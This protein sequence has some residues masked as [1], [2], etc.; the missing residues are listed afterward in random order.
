M[1]QFL[2]FGFFVTFV[3]L[4]LGASFTTVIRALWSGR[5]DA[6]SARWRLRL[7]AA[8]L[9]AM[10]VA[11]EV[12]SRK[13]A[14]TGGGIA[15]IPVAIERGLTFMLWIA[16]TLIGVR[17][18]LVRIAD[19]IFARW[20]ARAMNESVIAP[21][22]APSESPA[23]VL[24]SPSR[25]EALFHG[26]GI[27]IAS[28]TVAVCGYAGLRVAGELRVRDAEV[29]IPDLPPEFE[30]LTLVQLTDIHVGIFTGAR[31]FARV[32]ERTN[33]LRGDLVVLT[34]DLLDNNPD[35][36]P[37]A[38]RLFGQL[39]GRQGKYA[40]LGNHDYYAGYRL[41]LDGLPRVG[42]TPLVNEGIAIPGGRGRGALSLLGVDDVYASRME[43]GRGPD[44]ARA[45][46]SV[47]PEGPRIL[48]AHNPT[49]FGTAAG[50][51]ALQLS[52]HTHGGQFNPANVLGIGMKYVSGRYEARGSTLF[53]SN[54]IGITGP[55]M[56]L[57]AV[58]EIVRI[59]LT[60]RRRSG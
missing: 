45:I 29:Y 55:P 57:G 38:M 4:L 24:G 41:V 33:A 2:R 16:G 14:P 40:I 19:R 49:Y 34:G 35:H 43:P 27:A 37:D 20:A 18:L 39:R 8:A 44:L 26:S 5:F 12:L 51:I 30:G 59:G 9:V 21:A 15:R 54:G 56:R 10:T 7:S 23:A 6:P 31:D 48:L 3:T 28:T 58:P 25:R 13:Y 32:I 47:A 53:V 36:V 17:N 52:G 22:P 46:R 1:Q 60:G 42:I 50:N 11:I